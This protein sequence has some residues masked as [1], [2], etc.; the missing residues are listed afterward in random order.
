[1]IDA[2]GGSDKTLASSFR[3]VANQA[4]LPL[5]DQDVGDDRGPTRPHS[6]PRRGIARPQFL[7]RVAPRRGGEQALEFLF[8]LPEGLLRRHGSPRSRWR[9]CR[10]EHVSWRS[11]GRDDANPRRSATGGG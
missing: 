8:P 5:V 6:A 4:V 3:S 9:G 1:M 7:K 10:A 2:A 11:Q